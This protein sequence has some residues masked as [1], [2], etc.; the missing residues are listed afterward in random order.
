[1]DDGF[2]L[3]IVFWLMVQTTVG[4]LLGA[5]KN[6]ATAGT[7]LGFFLG[8]IGWLIVACLPDNRPRCRYCKE[9]LNPG[10]L[11]CPHCQSDLATVTT[12]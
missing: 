12:T 10:A 7:W 6:Q 9:A 8:V 3:W 5:R 11:K 4:A 2:W 1:M